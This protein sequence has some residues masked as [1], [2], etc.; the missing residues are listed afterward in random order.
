M[1]WR[2]TPEAFFDLLLAEIESHE[3]LRGYYRFLQSPSQFEFRKA[4]Y[5]QRLEYICRQV[6]SKPEAHIWDVGCGYGTTAI[7]LALNGYHVQGSTLEYYFEQIPKRL[8]YWSKHG[9][10]ETMKLDYENLFDA[11][12]ME[13]RFDFVI[14]QDTLHHLEPIETALHLI[15]ASLKP[16]GSMIA[17]EE[18]GSNIIQRTKLYLQRG[19]NRVITIRDEKLGKDILLGNENIRSIDR[20][21]ELCALQGLQVEPDSIHYVRMYPPAFFNGHNSKEVIAREQRIWRRNRVLRKFF[22]FGLDFT[23]SKQD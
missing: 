7:F 8:N 23:A 21:K 3:E 22:F 6:E 17:V 9:S 15:A 14:V 1:K 11:T 19:N 10:L 5:M 13:N 18:N 20:W 12:G 16:G 4:Y 2:I